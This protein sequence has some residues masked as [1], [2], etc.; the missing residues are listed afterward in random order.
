MDITA[1]N[2]LKQHKPQEEQEDKTPPPTAKHKKMGEVKTLKQD[3]PSPFFTSDGNQLTEVNDDSI[4]G[5]L[6]RLFRQFKID[7]AEGRKTFTNPDKS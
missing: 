7:Q 1:T 6:N 2:S 3:N 5:D 4:Y